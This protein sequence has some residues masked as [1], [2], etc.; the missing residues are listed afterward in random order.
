ML[1]MR[2]LV[3]LASLLAFGEVQAASAVDAQ[4]NMHVIRT[5]F[6]A[7]GESFVNYAESLRR[8][9]VAERLISRYSFGSTP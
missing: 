4:G 1:L 5:V 6:D 7:D 3:V 2:P 9:A 8:C